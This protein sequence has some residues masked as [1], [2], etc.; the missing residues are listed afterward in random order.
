MENTSKQC[1]NK[2][3]PPQNKVQIEKNTSKQ[4]TNKGKHIKIM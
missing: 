3:K 1:T 2:E 4:C